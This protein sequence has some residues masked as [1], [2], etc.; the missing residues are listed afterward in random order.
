MS[1]FILLGYRPIRPL[2]QSRTLHSIHKVGKKII[3]VITLLLL[4]EDRLLVLLFEL[5]DA[6]KRLKWIIDE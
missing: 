4:L 6:Q 5:A 1:G 3:R 2:L